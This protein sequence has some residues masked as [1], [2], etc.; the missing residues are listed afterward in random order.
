[1]RRPRAA[2][3]ESRAVRQ[4]GARTRRRGPQSEGRARVNEGCQGG[5]LSRDIQGLCAP[6][7][8]TCRQRARRRGSGRR[9]APR[10]RRA[11]HVTRPCAGAQACCSRSRSPRPHAASNQST[12]VHAMIGHHFACRRQVAH[13]TAQHSRSGFLVTRRCRWRTVALPAARPPR[14]RPRPWPPRRRCCRP[15][16]AGLRRARRH[17]WG[18]E[19]G[20]AEQ[21]AQLA[22]VM[23]GNASVRS[24]DSATSTARQSHAPPT[25]QDAPQ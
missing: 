22:V 17:A 21:P 2:A 7:P 5:L 12:S 25:S 23:N 19:R 4:P 24:A 1:M 20:A 13:W 15:A 11:R 3:A 18:V 6:W 9:A 8:A 14:L 16:A 10:L